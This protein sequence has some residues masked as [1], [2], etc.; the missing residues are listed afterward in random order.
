MSKIRIALVVVLLWSIVLPAVVFAQTQKAAWQNAP[1]LERKVEALLK[2]MT[3]EEKVGQLNQYSFGTP[4]GPGTGRSKVEE[5][6]QRGELGSLLNVT[7]PALSNRLQHIAMDQSRLK[8]PLIFGLDV[9]HGYRTTF[10]VPLALSAT[11]DANLVERVSCIAAEEAT[12]NGIRWTFSPM[13]DIARDPR[14]GRI[15]E[16]AGEDP[17]SEERRVG[18]ECR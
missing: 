8:I 5:A 6:I 3:L 9:I 11:W 13:V 2:Q 12:S 14:W 15:V 18:K 7:D 4:T 1:E 17:R 10:P 16:G